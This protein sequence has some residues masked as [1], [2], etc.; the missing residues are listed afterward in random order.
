MDERFASIS[1][2]LVVVKRNIVISLMHVSDALAS[3][4]FKIASS[5]EVPS[6]LLPLSRD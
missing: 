2:K 6:T 5:K 4:L 3:I 1:T